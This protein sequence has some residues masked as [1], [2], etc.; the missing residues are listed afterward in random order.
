MS[1]SIRFLT[2]LTAIAVLLTC[3]VAA[4][5]DLSNFFNR[6]Y[7]GNGYGYGGVLGYQFTV[8]QNNINVCALGLDGTNMTQENWVILWS[9]LDTTTPVAWV[10]LTAGSVGSGGSPTD[11]VGYKYEMLTAPI[12]LSAGSSYRICANAA[13]PYWTPDNGGVTGGYS[14]QIATVDGYVYGGYGVYPDQYSGWGDH[15]YTAVTFFTG[16][17]NVPEPGALISLFGGIAGMGA[18]VIRRRKA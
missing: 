6:T 13:G 8:G 10:H 1:R 11:S 17:A 3:A 7:P 12:T 5:A 18:L 14:T 9:V 2:V 15:I 16:S 4:N